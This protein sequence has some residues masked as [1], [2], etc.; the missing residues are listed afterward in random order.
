MTDATKE[1]E[2][3]PWL[4]RGLRGEAK[5]LARTVGRNAD[6][7]LTYLEI[8]HHQILPGGGVP[9]TPMSRK[10][11]GGSRLPLTDAAVD[12]AEANAALTSVLGGIL[13]PRNA[14]AGNLCN[15]EPAWRVLSALLF[16]ATAVRTW[17][18]EESDNRPQN[19]RAC[20]ELCRRMALV[21]AT[22]QGNGYVL[23]RPVTS[24]R[25]AAAVLAER[26]EQA[27]NPNREAPKVRKVTA[28]D[29]YRAIVRDMEAMVEDG[30]YSKE[31]AKWTKAEELGCSIW[32]VRDAIKFVNKERETLFSGYETDGDAA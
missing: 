16:D 9:E 19:M 8:V 31:A 22:R 6:R 29:S 1:T 13:R 5:M 2:E 11:R 14:P 4:G 28:H 23:P 3:N 18:A 12:I 24:A 26:G 32:R 17:R 10:E 7:I 25:T 21:L 15:G 20:E 27:K 30:D